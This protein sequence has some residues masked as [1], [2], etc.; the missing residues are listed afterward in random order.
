MLH[1]APSPSG[2]TGAKRGASEWAPSTGQQVGRGGPSVP[3]VQVSVG[4]EQLPVLF[5]PVELRLPPFGVG[6]AVVRAKALNV[7][8]DG[9]LDR[10][11][12]LGSWCGP[13]SVA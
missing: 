5:D 4:R 7:G 10:V 11:D 8:C 6:E 3:M 2:Q 9:S 12:D 13:V 1:T